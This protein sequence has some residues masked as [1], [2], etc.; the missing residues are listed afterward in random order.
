MN[1]F[2]MNNPHVRKDAWG[3][4]S[5]MLIRECLKRPWRKT[6]WRAWR[7]ACIYSEESNPPHNWPNNESPMDRKGW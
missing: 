1:N 5:I 2:T 6:R 4:V 3:A 7:E